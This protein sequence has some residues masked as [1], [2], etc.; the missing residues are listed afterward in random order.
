MVQWEYLTIDLSHVPLRT[1]EIAI[2]NEAGADGWELV[3]INANNM[4]YLKRP[5][6]LVTQPRRSQVE[7]ATRGKQPAAAK[8]K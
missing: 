8:Q 3:W 5:L 4:A 6:E 7:P 1:G 2:L